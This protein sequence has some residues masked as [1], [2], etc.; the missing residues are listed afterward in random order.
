MCSL[1]ILKHLNIENYLK[2]IIPLGDFPWGDKL[3]IG[4]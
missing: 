1:K 4:N 2:I 3:K